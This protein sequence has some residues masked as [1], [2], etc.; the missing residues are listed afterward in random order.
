M[1]Y[2]IIEIRSVTW[3]DG[4][5]IT[6]GMTR[7]E[8]EDGQC[9]NEVYNSGPGVSWIPTWTMTYLSEEEMARVIGV[10]WESDVEFRS[11]PFDP[12]SMRVM[13]LTIIDDSA[14]HVV[15]A[16]P[17]NGALIM[18][19]RIDV[20]GNYT[21]AGSGL[22]AIMVSLDAG[23]WE[24]AACNLG[25]FHLTLLGI[26]DGV[27]IVRANITDVV[28]NS[29]EVY[30]RDVV[31]DNTVPT[32]EVLSP[33]HYVN[34]YE[35][36]LIAR[37]EPDARATV[38]GAEVEVGAGGMFEADVLMRSDAIVIEIS[39]VD[40]VGH[41]N[42]TRYSVELDLTPP[43][44]IVERPLDGTWTSA[45]EVIVTGLTEL[46]ASVH[47]NDRDVP[48]EYTRFTQTV[49]VLEGR[50][51]I[52]VTSMD[53]AGNSAR[54][55]IVVNVDLT[56]PLVLLESPADG[57]T[58]NESTPVLAGHISDAGPVT[59]LVQGVQAYVGGDS[60][61]A[62]ADLS[63]GPNVIDL[64]AVD[65]AGNIASFTFH[66]V[67]DTTPPQAQLTL[68]VDGRPLTPG[69]EVTYT[70]AQSSELVLEL[71]ETCLVT[72]PSMG[73]RLVDAG[74]S[75]VALRLVEGYND[76]DVTVADAVG[77]G[78]TSHFHVT[79]DTTPPALR[80]IYPGDGLETMD[81]WVTVV[82][83]T[84]PGASL[85]VAGRPVALLEGGNFSYRVFLQRGQNT[86]EVEAVDALGNVAALSLHMD[87]LGGSGD[88]DGGA[89]A[90]GA[91]AALAILGV[92]GLAVLLMARGRRRAV[93]AG[94]TGRPRDATPE[95]PP[96]AHGGPGVRVRRGR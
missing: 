1:E 66:L 80:I 20:H 8:S 25:D 36:H 91:I 95:M 89:G 84:E 76:L 52:T 69:Q 46:G 85:T 87:R 58:V 71:G 57:G 88:P 11:A 34:V 5:P 23:P 16:A 37:T 60:W 24:R 12:R 26:P 51:I 56:P 68:R 63:E 32:I 40:R 90:G 47:V 18:V 64:T 27:H 73:E 15:V 77:N 70:R 17:L 50:R 13:N 75:T 7:I 55:I 49:R 96:E 74:E 38:D 93:E 29:M 54:A 41:A 10:F 59:L 44:L 94:R 21:E 43:E 31:T 86:F 82:G 48:L 9:L 28:G 35:V 67:V 65:A 6:D 4:T 19:N 42:S 2:S 45:Q 72:L 83:V 14:P 53:A 62:T 33:G 61:L 3:Q 79:R 78:A 92:L 30:V 22:R 39:V 81:D